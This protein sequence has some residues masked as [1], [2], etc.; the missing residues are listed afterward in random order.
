MHA[1]IHLGL[2]TQYGLAQLIVMTALHEQVL[3]GLDD[4]NAL[5]LLCGFGLEDFEEQRFVFF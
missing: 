2:K 5:N 3:G 1:G 4:L